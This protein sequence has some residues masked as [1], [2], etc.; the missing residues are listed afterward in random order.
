MAQP[1]PLIGPFRDLLDAIVV[2]FEVSVQG[3]GCR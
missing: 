3:V 2:G 1:L